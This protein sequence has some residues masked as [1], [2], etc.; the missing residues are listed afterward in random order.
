MSLFAKLKRRNVF[1][2]ALAY[3][4]AAWLLTEVMGMITQAF[5][6]PAWVLK[7]FIS[8]LASGSC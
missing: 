7:V 8:L 1:R 4:V 6:A 3:M 2:T 5:E